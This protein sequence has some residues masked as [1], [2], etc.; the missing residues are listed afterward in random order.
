YVVREYEAPQGETEELLAGIWAELLGVQRVGRSDNFFELG[1]HSLLALEA[2][3]KLRA[4]LGINFPIKDFHAAPTIATYAQQLAISDGERLSTS[5]LKWDDR[6][7]TIPL[8]H[9]QRRVWFM[10]NLD[11]YSTAYHTVATITL[12][13][14][15]HV[16]AFD[17]SLNDL[18]LRHEILRTTFE[19]TEGEPVQRVHPF[20]YTPLPIHDL[21]DLPE[22]S[23]EARLQILIDHL[24]KKRFSLHQLP[25][26]RWSL[27]K[28]SPK[29]H[30]LIQVEHHLIHDGFSFNI[31]LS[32]LTQLYALHS[33]TPDVFLDLPRPEFQYADFVSWERSWMTGHS[34]EEQMKYWIGRLSNCPPCLQLPFISAHGN[35]NLGSGAVVRFNLPLALCRKLRRFSARKGTTLFVTMLTS[36]VALLRRYSGQTDIVVGTA[37][38][39]RRY[40]NS[41]RIAGML[42]NSVALRCDVSGDP[43]ISEL[44][45][46]VHGVVSGASENQEYPFEKLVEIL[47][48]DRSVGTNPLFQTMFSFHDSRFHGVA[49]A[50]LDVTVQ[51][52]LSNGA[53]KLDID[54][55]I[56]PGSN[57]RRSIDAEA[58]SDSLTVLWE[59]NTG[60]LDEPTVQQMIS[61]YIRALEAMV[62]DASQKVD[63]LS[64][65]SDIERHQ[66]LYKWN[67]TAKEYP[68]EKCVHELFEEQVERTPEAIAVVF[69]DA[70][71]SY[72]EL[73]RRANLL[74]HYLRG[75]GVKSDTRV[76]LCV[77]R[78]FEMIV[79]LLA[80][81]KAGGAYMPLDPGYPAERLRFML[82]DSEPQ[83]VLTQEHLRDQFDGI[84]AKVPIVDL[85]MAEA[86]NN[87]PESNPGTAP[88]GLTSR[89]LACMIYTSGS[90]GTPKGVMVEH[91]SIVNLMHAERNIYSMQPEDRVYQGASLSFDTSVEEIWLTLCAGATVVVATPEMLHAGPDLCRLLMEYR[92]TVLSCVPTLLSTLQRDIPTIRLLILGGETCSDL[93]VS[94]WM[95]SPRRIVNSYGPTET[96][97]GVT[98]YEFRPE[99]SGSLPIGKPI[100][101]ARVYIL[102]GDRQPVPV[103][104]AG[105][106]Y[107]GGVAVTRGYWKRAQLT[108]ER[109]IADPFVTEP[110][111]RMYQTGD[112]GRWL[113]DGNIEFLGRNDYQVKIRGFRI[114]LG[115][116]EARL[117]EHAG[118]KEVVVILRED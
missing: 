108:A 100:A 92:V 112:M 76:A 13:G 102:D 27:V 118:V 75:L 65:L 69:G 116:I 44:L 46:R 31:L 83:V 14:V 80:V 7:L 52:G 5:N 6:P 78:G 1:G 20:Q 87:H 51:E 113:P 23:R 71:L 98:L 47:Q 94:Q 74:A 82:E 24:S 109:F 81:L 93:S 117:A 54:I 77:D 28:L 48:P 10:C 16:D 30:V 15:L 104:V 22:E 59:Y 79:G 103:G 21:S 95:R 29:H 70:S 84:N 55:V 96:T 106:I 91:R 12:T 38:A 66:V 63:S 3:S 68:A 34:A 45:N 43:T 114:E 110:Q 105:E 53:A 56:I 2:V 33:K 60:R 19:A 85:M 9:S 86:W 17:K 73:N 36:F 64:L 89:N 99:D 35:K 42:V 50:G 8:S 90:T 111:A 97:V 37:F 115:E 25:L 40:P 49:M 62:V 72:A 41:E 39:N 88:I 18:V 11:P 57:A 58:P 67:A 26:I 4:Q 32:E 61:H 107:I 101:N